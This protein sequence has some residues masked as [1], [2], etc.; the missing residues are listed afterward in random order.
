MTSLVRLDLTH[1][2]VAVEVL[3]LQRMA[4]AVEAGIIGFD[5][6]P[7][8]HESLDELQQR[9]YTWFGLVDDEGLGGA[10]AYERQP[11]GLIDI[12]RL[13]V[14]PR[15]FR[16]G[17]GRAL[18]TAVLDAEQGPIVTVSTGSLNRPALT[19]YAALGFRESGRREIS[20]GVSVTLLELRR[21]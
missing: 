9:T 1:H 13:V 12:C 16:R 6:I 21:T 8:L 14:A 10:I 2:V 15:A 4:Y 17:Y 18:T 5:G 11:D 19:L 7:P 20:P 3:A